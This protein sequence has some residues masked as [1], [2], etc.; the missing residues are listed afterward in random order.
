MSKKIFFAQEWENAHFNKEK[1][2][3]SDKKIDNKKMADTKFDIECIVQKI[4]S[5][6]I[7]IAPQY[8]DWVDVGFALA[9]GL[10][11]TGREFF[12]R[13]SANHPSYDRI[14]TDKQY[15][16]CL[17][18]KGSGITIATF[19]HYA[20]VAGIFIEKANA[21]FPNNRNGKTDK[22]IKTEKELPTIPEAVYSK[23]PP[24]L[25]E[26]ACNSISIEDRDTI[27]LGAI[28]SLSACLN[29][30]C[31][32]YDERIVYPNLYLFV[33]ADA[34]MGKGALTLC[35]ELVAPIHNQLHES[36]KS[37]EQ[38]Y[39][40]ALS[41]S[42]NNKYSVND[43]IPVEPPM[44]MLIIPGNSSASSFLKILSDNDGIGLLFETEGD[45]LSQTLKSDYGN[46]SDI[47][48]KA[49]HHEMVSVSRRKDREFREIATPRLSVVLAGTPEQ[50]R[51]LIPDTENGLMSRFIFYNIRFKRGIRNVFA[52]NDIRQSKNAIFK[53]L[54]ER[55]LHHYQNFIKRGNFVF[56]I[57]FLQQQQFIEFLD[58]INDE[59]CDEV[60]NG[61]Q[62]VI[63]RIGLIAF[64][65][66]MVLSAIRKMTEDSVD[67]NSAPN[68]IL[69]CLPMDYQTAMSICNTLIYH[70]VF[71]YNKLCRFKDGSKDQNILTGPEG[72]RNYVLSLLPNSF[73]KA[74]YDTLV[75][76]LNENISTA[77]K[78]INYFIR[79]GK[80]IRTE[81]GQY[82]KVK[83]LPYADN[84]NNN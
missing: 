76:K 72:R 5:C 29:N 63:R 4:E 65:I 36:T 64:R 84:T 45:T 42:H 57:P 78:W 52:I 55:F 28:V 41:K 58:K 3:I 39:R 26:I 6:K 33:V 77:N 74:D 17:N 48:R 1:L 75:L 38:E 21:I 49:F 44:K 67:E 73:S 8:K 23:L 51:R 18:G 27:L 43:D 34:G 19:F 61:M 60:G 66:M 69:E 7:D 2:I 16:N 11:E 14:L 68:N 82:N 15:T 10:G 31:G 46:Y 79:D 70:S 40:N 53:I 59:C 81:Q 20:S 35:R 9:D 47:L 71:I 25:N 50:V 13:I 32:V 30:I 80:I 56:T 62:G 24:F 22:W 12:H 83:S 54:G 37:M